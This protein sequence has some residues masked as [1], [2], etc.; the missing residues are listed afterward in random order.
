MVLAVVATLGAE[1][2]TALRTWFVRC[3]GTVKQ[4]HR[5]IAI[6][7]GTAWTLQDARV[8][9][10]VDS[11]LVAAIIGY[12]I[13]SD[14][15][16]ACVTVA[17]LSLFSYFPSSRVH[18]K[19]PTV[20]AKALAAVSRLFSSPEFN[21][22]VVESLETTD[23]IITP[24][25]P[26]DAEIGAVDSMSD[27]SS[28]AASLAKAW[29]ALPAA[30]TERCDDSKVMVRRSALQALEALFALSR[31]PATATELATA[32]GAAFRR[33]MDPALSIRCQALQTAT[34]AVRHLRA[35][36]GDYL[37]AVMP[38]AFDSEDTVRTHLAEDL[39]AIALD[40]LVIHA[41][42]GAHHQDVTTFVF[43]LLVPVSSLY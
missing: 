7:V 41:V 19:A 20:R 9:Q 27:A 26:P 18:D 33:C 23:S 38:L 21:T 4:Q 29:H 39:A 37:E 6:E 22:H 3:L 28:P 25:P 40:G 30:I 35:T 1:R 32:A 5:T 8:S 24:L 34:A 12:G 42:K 2:Q 15:F 17:W 31:P 10:R 16:P 43:G 13:W 11:P 36:P 14:L